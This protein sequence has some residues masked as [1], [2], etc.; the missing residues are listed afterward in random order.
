VF[1]HLD[2]ELNF[3][4]LFQEMIDDF[5]EQRLMDRQAAILASV[6]LESSASD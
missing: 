4:R 5:T 2:A 1:L 3:H 6:G